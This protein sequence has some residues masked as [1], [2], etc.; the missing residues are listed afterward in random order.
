MTALRESLCRRQRRT[1]CEFIPGHV[2]AEQEAEH[3]DEEADAQDDD[4]DV[5]GQVE[6]LLRCHGAVK[7][8]HLKE[9]AQECKSE[10]D[11]RQGRRPHTLR[12]R[13]L[14]QSFENANEI[15]SNSRCATRFMENHQILPLLF[16]I[17]HLHC[18]GTKDERHPSTKNK[19]H[20]LKNIQM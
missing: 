19:E 3:E 16:C 6:E 18:S 9:K 1:T 20:F 12:L 2:A 10:L 13:F 17:S 8:D 14:S 7:A 11:N 5:E 4:V 15:N